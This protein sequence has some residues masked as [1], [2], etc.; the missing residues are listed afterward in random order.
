M[1]F[2]RNLTFA[3]VGVPLFLAAGNAGPDPMIWDA[4]LK[5]YV[6]GEAR[7]DYSR[8]KREGV[9]ELDAFLR[10]VAAPWPAAMS[11][12]ARKAAWINTYN[13]LTVRW[14]LAHYPVQSIMQTPNPFR[15]ARHAVGGRVVS[16][17]QVESQLRRL[18]DP[19][20]H[21]VLVCAARGCPPLRREAYTA[22]RIEAQLDENTRVWLANTKLNQ[23]LPERNVASV[24]AIFKWYEDDFGSARELRA[25]LARHAAEGKGEF[26]SR[27]EAKLTFK[28]YDWGLNDASRMGQDYAPWRLYWDVAVHYPAV[29]K[30]ALGLF[31]ASAGGAV[32]LWLR[33]RG[34]ARRGGIIPASADGGGACGRE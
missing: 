34:A 23:F 32:W 11:A 30:G 26:L 21:S 15:A 27:P 28:S 24:S 8:W 25:F 13:A 12:Q 20:I 17:D 9:Q 1:E 2:C 29:G 31:V 6:N 4:L 18:G 10:Q 22:E 19:R 3:L 14:V 33:R 16:L 5:R 7:V